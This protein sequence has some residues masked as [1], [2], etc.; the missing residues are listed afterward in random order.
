MRCSN[1]A[2]AF[3]FQVAFDK[4]RVF[5]TLRDQHP[6]HREFGR[7][8]IVLN[9]HNALRA[10][11][12]KSIGRNGDDIGWRGQLDGRGDPLPGAKAAVRIG[13]LAHKENGLR[14]R[15]DD[16]RRTRLAS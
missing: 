13:H 6:A 3:G 8:G 1:V 16:L 7:R 10:V 15:I 14:V 12:D 4:H 5:Q 2:A 11:L 9:Q